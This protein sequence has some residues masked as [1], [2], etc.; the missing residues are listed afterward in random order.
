MYSDSFYW[1]FKS[2]ILYH[3]TTV[4]CYLMLYIYVLSSFP[5]DG[6]KKACE[7]STIPSLVILLRDDNAEVRA[8]AAGAL[9]V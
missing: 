9:M 2:K 4:C 5:L 6:K 7:E 8:K 3:I 1:L